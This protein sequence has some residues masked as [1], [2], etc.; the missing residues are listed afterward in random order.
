MAQN[1]SSKGKHTSSQENS[2]VTQERYQKLKRRVREIQTEYDKIAK[3]LDR[4]RKRIKSLKREKDQYED[5]DSSDSEQSVNIS[6]DISSDSDVSSGQQ[7]RAS[8]IVTRPIKKAR[9]RLTNKKSASL[10]APANNIVNSE[11]IT[12][13]TSGKVAKKR[14]SKKPLNIKTMKVQYVEKD[15]KGN[16]ILPVQIGIL[17][18]LSLGHVVYDRDTFHNERYI[19]PVGYAVR[20][21]YNSMINPDSQTMYTCRIE[22]GIDGPRFVIEAE[23]Q[24]NKPIP[25]NTATG[26]WT[27]VVREA[28]A[29]RNR[30]HSNSASGP[31]YFGFSQA[32]IRKMIQ[33]LPN[34]NKCKNYVIQ[35]FEVINCKAAVA[36]GPGQLLKVEV[37]PPKR[38][39]VRVKILASGVCH[40]DAYTLSGKDPEG[41]NWP[42][43]FGHEGG[44][45]VESVGE[46]VTSV[47]PGDHVIPL[48]IPECRECKFCKS[49]K[50]NL[51]SS[52]RSTQGRGLMPDE[53]TRFTCKGQKVFHY[54]G[55]STFSQYTVIVEMSV[56]KINPKAPLDKVCLLGC[57]ITTGYG[58]AIKTADVQPG[59]T[60]A[61]F[62]CGGVGL[63]V[64]QGAKSRNASQ[65]I[66]I[67]INPKKF[68]FGLDYTFECT[69]NTKVM[70][71]AFESCHKGWGQ[72]IIIGVAGAGEEISTRPFQ[73]VT[74]RV[75][76]GSAFG[77]VKGR[78]EL[79]GLVEDYLDKKLE[80][81]LFITH[82]FKLEEIN[83]SFEAMHEGDRA[84][85]MSKSSA[86]TNRKFEPCLLGSKPDFTVMTTKPGKYIELLLG[87]SNLK[88]YL[89][90]LDRAFEIDYKD[91]DNFIGELREQLNGCLSACQKLPSDICSKTSTGHPPATP[92]SDIMHQELMS[93]NNIDE[94]QAVAISW[95]QSMVQIFHS[96]YLEKRSEDLLCHEV[97]DFDKLPQSET[98]SGYDIKG[99]VSW[100]YL[101]EADKKIA[102][103]AVISRIHIYGGLPKS[104]IG[105]HCTM[106]MLLSLKS[107]NS[108]ITN[109]TLS[110][111]N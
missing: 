36:W 28:N 8:S 98:S 92:K 72:S 43:I 2:A 64:I 59:S 85:L 62:G 38:G 86:T 19:W 13:H 103:L 30:D 78:S 79:P 42:V 1:H 3:E 82:K 26:A 102:A 106:A 57:G 25:A 53:T 71:A 54:M 46:G 94:A 110:S 50:T 27:S 81:D 39:E 52:V 73:L 111:G 107:S 58:A 20:R 37:A 32:T 5:T 34:S 29:I 17:T 47:Q 104:G 44:G 33:D 74:G 16:Y 60:V 10:P 95:L 41:K 96:M 99:V 63:S 11:P 35:R 77:G 56:A 9:G 40:T 70:R 101:N 21:A 49:G 65:I 24:P 18:V 84:N 68:E 93:V 88:K 109:V 87:K 100:K 7:S 4:S 12:T 108:N 75:W 67:D 97:R 83:E 48:Y 91:N 69:G 14:A 31:D 89:I 51:C 15:E 55:C 61:V 105:Y 90:K 66:A 45:I 23:D 6:S 22:D 80:V 76:K